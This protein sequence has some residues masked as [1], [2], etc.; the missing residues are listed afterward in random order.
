MVVVIQMVCQDV[1]DKA[2]VMQAHSSIIYHHLL[3]I[4][5]AF[6]VLFP[7]FNM[8]GDPD[9]DP[10]EDWLDDNKGKPHMDFPDFFDAMF[11]LA[12]VWCEKISAENYAALL[13]DLLADA[14]VQEGIFQV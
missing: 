5:Y 3:G 12:D 1:G 8:E 13:I 9:Y 11:E 14:K 2:E 6:Q 7:R 4:S 10:E